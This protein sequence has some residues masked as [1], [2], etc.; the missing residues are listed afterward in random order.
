MNLEGARCQLRNSRV[1][2]TSVLSVRLVSRLLSL[3]SLLCLFR[4]SLL[5]LCV[6]SGF[7]LNSDFNLCVPRLICFELGIIVRAGFDGALRDIG[8]VIILGITVI[9][10]SVLGAHGYVAVFVVRGAILIF[11]VAITLLRGLTGA[12]LSVG[13]GLVGKVWIVL[14]LFHDCDI[15]CR[16]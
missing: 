2:L 8:S 16:V 12:M 13:S 11:A 9:C 14:V 1:Q 3:F 10:G 6:D 15:F 5:L 4:F 7:V